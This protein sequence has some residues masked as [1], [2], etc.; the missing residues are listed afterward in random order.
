[1]RSLQGKDGGVGEGKQQM[2]PPL[3]LAVG[4]WVLE[5]FSVLVN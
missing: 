2:R 1:M 3:P 4:Q 5:S